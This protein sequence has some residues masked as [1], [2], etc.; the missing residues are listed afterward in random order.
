MKQVLKYLFIPLIILT[1]SN[2]FGQQD[3]QFSQYMFNPLGVNPAYAGS[4]EAL[5]AVLVHRSQWVGLDGA[6]NTQT[7]SIHSP[8]KNKNM[9]VGL[10]VF[11]DQ[12]GP[13]NTVGAI[14]S[15]A[16]RIKLGKGKLGF[17]LG[18]GIY[19][20]QFNWDKIDYK[21]KQDALPNNG[22]EN[23][24]APTFDF[25]LYYHTNTFYAGLEVDHLNQSDL[26]ILDSA[27]SSTDVARQYSHMTA[28]AGKAFVLNDKI[29]LKPSVLIRATEN[30]FGHADINASVLFDKK[31]WAG[32]SYRTGYGM[33]MIL[34][35]N[36]TDKLRVGYSYDYMM[37]QQNLSA[38]GSHEIMLG[39]DF[40]IFKSKLASPRY[41]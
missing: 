13:K 19:N 25:G 3:P 6:P 32:V 38:T 22:R 20:Y 12:I 14:A 39:Y 34:E 10:Q 36:I 11:N 5:S 35:Y 29:T 40:N 41:F 17:G 28:I 26:A 15:Y 30:G 21:D 1:G 16:Y 2:V 8:L 18:A 27:I 4:R 7:F 37:G 24:S 33:V 31:L 9:G 23:F